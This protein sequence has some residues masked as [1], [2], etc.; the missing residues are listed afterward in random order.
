MVNTLP[1]KTV[2]ITGANS[3]IG[4]AIVRAFAMCASRIGLHYLD[5]LDTAPVVIE[6]G[7][8]IGTPSRD[9]LEP[10]LLP[11][12]PA[13]SVGRWPSY[14]PICQIPKPSLHSLMP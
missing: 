13:R 7:V 14:L 9:A 11:L 10:R 1:G 6:S 3:G 12:K 2:L 8:H 5:Y 4:A